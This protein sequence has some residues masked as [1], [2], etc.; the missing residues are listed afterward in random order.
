M[1]THIAV[2]LQDVVIFNQKNIHLTS[3]DVL[4]TFKRSSVELRGLV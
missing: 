3:D 2:I 1:E 4:A